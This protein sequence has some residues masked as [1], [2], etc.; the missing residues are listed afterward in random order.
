VQ[1]LHALHSGVK[2]LHSILLLLHM[3]QNYILYILKF[4]GSDI[5]PDNSV[6]V[7]TV[8]WTTH[9]SS[10][11]NSNN[12]DTLKFD[13]YIEQTVCVHLTIFLLA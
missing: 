11:A 9:L 3:Q 4:S 10:R 12:S 13:H 8:S 2:L 1:E 6:I 7:C 5:S